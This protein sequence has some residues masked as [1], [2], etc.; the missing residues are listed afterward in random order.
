MGGDLPQQE[1]TGKKFHVVF[2]RQYYFAGKER[3]GVGE[4]TLV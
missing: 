3:V 2:K 4:V 1:V